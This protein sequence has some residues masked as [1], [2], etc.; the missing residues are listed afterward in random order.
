VQG[1]TTT[2]YAYGN[3]NRLATS[4]VGG[5]ITSC[6]YDA[7]EEPCLAIEREHSH[8]LSEQIPL[9]HLDQKWRDQHGNLNGRHLAICPF[10]GHLPRRAHRD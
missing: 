2:T 9:D 6:G 1:A 5:I 8:G 10:P 4:T 7:F 3:L